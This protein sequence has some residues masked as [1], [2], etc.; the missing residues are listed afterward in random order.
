M[1]MKE[2]KQ[3]FTIKD[4]YDSLVVPIFTIPPFKLKINIMFLS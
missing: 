3:Y 4:N 1:L 2:G